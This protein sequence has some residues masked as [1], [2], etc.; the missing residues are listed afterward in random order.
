MAEIS[1]QQYA[2][3]IED[4]IEQGR[5]AEAVAHGK[6]VLKQ[7]PKH[8]AT[9]QL[10][11][12]AMLEAGQ[13]DHATDMFRRVLS[14]DPENLIAWAGMSEI[15]TRR[16]ELDSAVWYMERAYEMAPDNKAVEEELRHLYGRR[17]GVE[18]Q[19]VQLTRGALARLYLKG[20]LLSR[21]VNELRELVAQDPDRPDLQVTLAEALWR[22]EQ[23][24]EAAEICQQVLDAMPYCLKANL[25]LGEVWTSSGRE[26]GEVYLRRAEA[27]DPENQMAQEL[28]GATSPLIAREMRIVPLE[29]V[30]PPD[31]ERPAWMTELD[32]AAVG[33]QPRAEGEMPLVDVPATLEGQIEIPAWLEEAVSEEAP[34][35]G[36]P[37]ATQRLPGVTQPLGAETLEGA[38]AEVSVPPGV[39]EVPEWLRDIDRELGEEPETTIE[40]VEAPEWL[41]GLGVAATEGQLRDEEEAA[42]YPERPPALAADQVEEPTATGEEEVPEWLAELGIEAAHEEAVAAEPSA[43]QSPDWLA[44]IRGQLS[45]DIEPSEEEE[46]KEEYPTMAEEG[47]PEWLEDGE[48]LP[49]AAEV[50]DWLR[51]LAPPEVAPAEAPPPAYQPLPEEAIAQPSREA[52]MRPAEEEPGPEALGEPESPP[53]AAAVAEEAP[54]AA[55]E[56]EGA[57]MPAWLEGEG[58]PSGDDALAWLEQLAEG[59]EEE[60]RAQAQ[61]EAETRMAEIM[62]RPKPAEAGVPGG[63]E[64]PTPEEAVAPAAEEAVD[65]TALGEAEAPPPQEAA[66]EEAEMPPTEEF[67][68]PSVEEPFTWPAVGEPEIPPEAAAVA[69]EAPAAAGEVEGAP[70]PAWLEGEGLPS[71]DD[72]LAWLEQLAEGK[73]EEL[74]AQAQAEAETRMAEIMGRPKPAEAGVPGGAEVPAPEE[75]VAPAAEEAVDWTAFGEVEAML[76]QEAAPEEAEMPPVEEFVA[77]PAEEPFTWPAVGEPEAPPEA[78]AAAEEAPP[79]IPEPA[80]PEREEIPP[81]AELPAVEEAPPPV[82]VREPEAIRPPEEAVVPAPVVEEVPEPVET[83]VTEPFGAERAHLKK[84]PRDYDAWL[85][86][87]RA[88][89]QAGERDDALEAYTRVIRSGKMLDIL[90]PDL[91]R[92]LKQWPDVSVQ[93]VLGDA[94]MKDGQL[95]KALDIYR[96]A[97]ETL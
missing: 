2:Q 77:P 50:P 37:S 80:R 72:A 76:T 33:R 13:D 88:L 93:R 29:Y 17:D 71:G 52:A 9:Y 31:E 6:H 74:R 24:L 21:A 87:A 26:E 22:N 94:Y 61:A 1:I 8:A 43:E 42:E 96:R 25:I 68:A 64:I 78:A 30:P 86:L 18:T 60:L 97:L 62:G 56:V 51:E 23:R 54:V 44:D 53:E 32:S 83:G 41:A 48:M 57:P 69:E 85:S 39:D 55:G 4:E 82:Q 10:L 38:P 47:M 27:V 75:A 16:S 89:W 79:E 20:D 11:G 45:Q 28:F 92:R 35:P 73:E 46:E 63:D 65:W 5:Y 95:Q 3:Q 14:A 91:E 84:H 12:K 66:P 36:A 40:E 7:Y 58:L 70:M 49:A 90:I 67:V 59:K 81:A 15:H 34:A 19:R